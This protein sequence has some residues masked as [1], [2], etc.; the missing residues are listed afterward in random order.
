MMRESLVFACGLLVLS[1][2][3]VTA[4]SA[5]SS[6]RQTTALSAASHQQQDGESR[7][8]FFSKTAGLAVAGLGVPYLPMDVANAVTGTQ[9]VNAKLQGCVHNSDPISCWLLLL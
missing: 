6:V 2:A 7:R 1:S 8:R 5:S 3:L 4:F 9:K